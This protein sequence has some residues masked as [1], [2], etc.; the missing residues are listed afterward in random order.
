[1]KRDVFNTLLP[2]LCF[3]YLFPHVEFF[4]GNQSSTVELNKNKQVTKVPGF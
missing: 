3:P 4:I 2:I 1:M